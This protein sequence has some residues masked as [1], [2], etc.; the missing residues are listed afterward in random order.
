[1]SH[2]VDW[3]EHRMSLEILIEDMER[4]SLCVAPTDSE[5]SIFGKADSLLKDIKALEKEQ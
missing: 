4:K 1:M 3:A 5:V 2:E